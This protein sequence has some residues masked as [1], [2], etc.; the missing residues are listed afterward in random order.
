MAAGF[1]LAGLLRV[2]RIKE[3]SAAGDAA[4][5]A[6]KLREHRSQREL[7]LQELHGTAEDPVDS[8]SLLAIAAAR[9]ASG[10]ALSDL[11]ALDEILE[12]AAAQADAAYQRVRMELKTVEKLEER[13]NTGQRAAQLHREQA[14][15]DELAG[16]SAER[17]RS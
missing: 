12:G 6:A 14:L 9:S 10:A 8:D 2:R 1:S 11:A 7:R 5:A 15:L 3:R 4:Q 17:K 16:R 13:H